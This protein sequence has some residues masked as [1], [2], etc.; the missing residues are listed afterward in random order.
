MDTH[1]W[2]HPDSQPSQQQSGFHNNFIRSTESDE[3]DFFKHQLA[4]WC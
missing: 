3:F 2:L 1:T 4:N